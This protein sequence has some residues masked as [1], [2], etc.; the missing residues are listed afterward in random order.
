[1]NYSNAT[2][3][4]EELQAQ[5]QKW[6]A[7]ALHIN[8]PTLYNRLQQAISSHSASSKK[9]L[10]VKKPLSFSIN[11][12]ILHPNTLA[13]LVL[14]FTFPSNYPEETVCVVKATSTATPQQS[15]EQCT[16]AI[17]AYLAQS[18]VG[19]ECI[20][21]VMEW[22]AEHNTT[23]LSPG[24]GDTTQE[25][26]VECYVLRYNHLLQGAEHKKEKNMV[27]CAKKDRLKGGI[28]W[29]T[30]GIVVIVPPSN[31]EDAKEYASSCR[32]LGKR[33]DGVEAVHFSKVGWERI[34]NSTGTEQKKLL[35]LTIPLLR[36]LAGDDETLLK[37]VLGVV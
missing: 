30:P 20:D 26:T 6:W 23:C 24:T 2:R 11:C 18:F 17:N 37:N 36:T 7:H 27:D 4:V 34:W 9:V 1:M 25:D 35:D 33:P 16:S 29:G 19:C 31:E 10:K 12:N 8:T 5:Q 14:E 15:C 32:T 13:T 22:I 28:L 21:V 3:Q